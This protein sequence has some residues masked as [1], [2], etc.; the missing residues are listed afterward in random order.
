MTANHNTPSPNANRRK[1]KKLHELSNCEI[2][3]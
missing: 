3:V 1:V 2:T